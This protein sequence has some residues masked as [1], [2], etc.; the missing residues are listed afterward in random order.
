MSCCGKNRAEAQTRWRVARTIPA[1]APTEA[2][3]RTALVFT[4]RHPY[5][6]S[7]ASSR[8]IYAFTPGHLPHQV[9]SRDVAALLC[10]GLF[11]P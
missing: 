1:P 9:D 4:G 5:L 2:P 8:E 11:T 10:T 3:P 7:G 6:A